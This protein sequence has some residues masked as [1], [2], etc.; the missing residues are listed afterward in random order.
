[1]RAFPL[2]VAPSL[3]GRVGVGLTTH[4]LRSYYEDSGT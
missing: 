1:M 2:L 3:A 4:N